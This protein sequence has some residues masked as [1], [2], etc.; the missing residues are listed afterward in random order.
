MSFT[1]TANRNDYTGTG[2]IT[3][4]DY[5]FKILAATHL[6]V[7]IRNSNGVEVVQSYPTQYTVTGV[8][9]A[10]GGTV[11][12]STALPSGHKL[13]IV[14]WLPLTQPTDIRNQGGYYPD[15]IEDQLD[16]FGYEIL[17]L[18]D[19][20]N[21]APQV[22]I[23]ENSFSNAI[24]SIESRG[25]TLMGWDANGAIA[26]YA[27]VPNI[28]AGTTAQFYRGDGVFSSTLTGNL[29]INTT[30]GGRFEVQDSSNLGRGGYFRTG[31]SACLLSSNSGVISTAIG[32]DGTAV[33]EVDT[34][35]RVQIYAPTPGSNPLTAASNIA[36]DSW[37]SHINANVAGNSGFQT[38]QAGGAV[39][40]LA[41]LANT[42]G[43]VGTST[44]HSFSLL[45]NGSSR[46]TINAAGGLTIANPTSGPSLTFGE[47]TTTVIPGTTSFRLR[48]NAN[49]STNW[50]V[51][52]SGRITNP[53]NTQ[54]AYAVRASANRT[55]TGTFDTY[56][57]TTYN[58]GSHVNASTGLFT[59]PVDGLHIF[60]ASISALA[61]VGSC[62]VLVEI[63]A[64]GSVI[65]SSLFSVGT[66]N[67]IIVS[68]TG[69]T[70][71]G[72]SQ[73]AYAQVSSITGGT[74]SYVRCEYFQGTL[75]F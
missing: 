12:L 13:A 1:T 11:I 29:T 74:I 60:A 57:T 37:I 47:A 2:A 34:N 40:T 26:S 23:T 38:S 53:S 15:T 61:S 8:G 48:N 19:Q 75:L 5:T 69:M 62:V 24:P 17:Q 28:A 10:T 30:T 36:G 65:A 9:S 35:K 54:P 63:V 39:V 32:Q 7:T 18:Q 31:A 59:A 56:G 50:Q 27:S 43:Y 51:T 3:T 33:I 22:P 45:S 41:A 20:L 42:S 4:Y 73:T 14:R 55:T 67:S 16:R 66:A 68:L 44:N 52:D 46:A 25:G 72:S 70:R 71:L 58:Q 49:S 64:G 21:R 6:K